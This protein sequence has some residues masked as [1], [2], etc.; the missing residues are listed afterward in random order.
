M[1]LVIVTVKREHESR[2]RD[3]VLPA[4]A[5]AGALAVA[6]ARGLG[7]S[8]DQAGQPLAYSIRIFPPGRFLQPHE[9]L[10]TADA[11]DGTWLVLCP[12]EQ[13]VAPAQEFDVGWEELPLTPLASQGEREALLAAPPPDPARPP[14]PPLQGEDLI[15]PLVIEW[16]QAGPTPERAPNP[17]PATQPPPQTPHG[18]RRIDL[19]E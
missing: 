4:D 11:W 3:I 8:H 2:V 15:E 6:L 16:E 18:W 14:P 10:A 1:R 5:P 13:A 9:T 7:W 12:L 19:D 17:D